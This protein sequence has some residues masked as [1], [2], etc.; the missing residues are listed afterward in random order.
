MQE[1]SLSVHDWVSSEP[2][3]ITCAGQVLL[4]CVLKMLSLLK[5][6]IFMIHQKTMSLFSL[7]A[8]FIYCII[9][10]FTNLKADKQ[11][12]FPLYKEINNGTMR[13]V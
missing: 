7:L 11:L 13:V 5:G 9:T 3:G 8:F 6:A 1:K 10:V 4:H 2:I 12:A